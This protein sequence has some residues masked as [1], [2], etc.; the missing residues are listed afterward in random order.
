M[1]IEF[2]ARRAGPSATRYNLS[3]TL[4]TSRAVAVTIGND[5]PVAGPGFVVIVPPNAVHS[6][7]A[8][9]KGKAIDVNYPSRADM[10]GA[11]PRVAK[12]TCN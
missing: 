9:N 1:G 3:Q 8:I 5:S 12:Q 10:G 7:K 6:V 11:N 2:Q 4:H